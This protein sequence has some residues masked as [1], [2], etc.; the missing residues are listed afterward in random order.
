MPVL[1]DRVSQFL[2][3]ATGLLERWLSRVG[4]Q[5]TGAAQPPMSLVRRS[6]DVEFLASHVASVSRSDVS[7]GQRVVNCS[8]NARYRWRCG[9]TFDETSALARYHP[10]VHPKIETIVPLLGP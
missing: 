1:W 10:A 5:Q 6:A 2:P 3:M 7:F 4:Q 8:A 9:N